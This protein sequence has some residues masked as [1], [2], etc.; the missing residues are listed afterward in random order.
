MSVER[1][2]D[3]SPMELRYFETVYPANEECLRRADKVRSW[4]GVESL[5]ERDNTFMQVG[6]DCAWWLMHYAEVEARMAH[7]EG[8]GLA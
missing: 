5:P 7:G 1:K 2:D 3:E 4:I 8:L 6:D